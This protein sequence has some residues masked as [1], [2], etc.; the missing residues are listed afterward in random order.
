MRKTLSLLSLSLVLISACGLTTA[1][2][3]NSTATP[4]EAPAT[5]A[6]QGKK[7]DPAT[8][9]SV[10]GKITLTGQ[11]P[12]PDVMR[13]AVDQTC[14]AAM[15]TTAKSD[16]V[17]VGPDGAVQN[18]FV[19]IKDALSDYTFDVPTAPV[20]LDQVGCRYAPR[21]F[22]VRVGQPLEMVNSDATLHNVHA[23]P[24]VNQEFNRGTPR[25]NDR[26]TQIF[27][28]PEQMVRFKCDL[29]AWM[30]AYGGIM[31]HPFFQVTG[32]DGAYA[33]KGIPPGKYE[34]TVWTEKL[35][36]ATQTIEIGNSQAV[37]AN[38]TLSAD[39][40]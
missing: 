35:G 23:M 7:V 19:Y 10:A 16:A 38:F 2:G 24:M 4:A 1:C 21:V 33:L 18:A 12:V 39:K 31:P 29:H 32:A 26:I 30:N 5:A 27:T 22:G 20:V 15:G 36:T 40:K 28:A 6:R 9:G 14:I 13:V 8:A 37:S 11:A 25:Q 3:G 17:L 34:L